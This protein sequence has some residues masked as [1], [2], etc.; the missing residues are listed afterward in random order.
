MG[1][2]LRIGIVII[3]LGIAFG[4]IAIYFSKNVDRWEGTQ[5]VLQGFGDSISDIDLEEE[6]PVV[7][8]EEAQV[9]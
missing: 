5:D 8:E 9:E 3:I 4:M 7:D 2:A 6:E 1:L